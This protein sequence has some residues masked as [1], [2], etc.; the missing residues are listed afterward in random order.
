[1]VGG[2]GRTTVPHPLP[3]PTIPARQLVSA[4]W[5]LVSLVTIS[6][7][8]VRFRAVDLTVVGTDLGYFLDAARDAVSGGSVY[9]GPFYVYSPLVAWFLRPLAWSPDA[10]AWW[11][12]LGIVACLVA[13]AATVWAL[14]PT[15]SSWERPLVA[16]VGVLTALGDSGLGVELALGQTDT[17]VLAVTAVALLLYRRGRP[18]LSGA[19][20]AL[21]ALVKTWPVVFVM[22]LLRAGAR[23]R[24][25]SLLGYLGLLTGCALLVALVTGP[26]EVV[27]WIER[28]HAMSD[29]KFIVWSAWGVGTELFTDRGN[30]IPIVVS[31]DLA[32]AT[33]VALAALVIAA[34][35][36][37]LRRPAE[38]A[39]SLWHIVMGAVL[40]LPVS[41]DQYRVLFLPL[42][43][44]WFASALR[45]RGDVP[46][47]AAFFVMMLRW[48]MPWLLAPL[49]VDDRWKFLA[50]MLT[51][52]TA[53]CVS[54]VVAAWFMH[55]GGPAAQVAPATRHA[56]NE[57]PAA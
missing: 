56:K 29:Q 22:W 9:E 4:M 6:L 30:F 7:S 1:M 21:A 12:V 40:L 37:V 31:T 42:I 34:L 38:S 35:V 53:L 39:L 27:R 2:F 5:V 8:V 25:R 52:I 24:A 13:V 15:L 50:I 11:T 26:G 49:G 14:A 10:F 44:V 16:L 19:V 36:L 55:R 28:T 41:H 45:T 43:W 51:D 18:G 33:D 23:G 46:A 3:R 48:A 17:I 54:V 47:V 32:R 57:R 20:L